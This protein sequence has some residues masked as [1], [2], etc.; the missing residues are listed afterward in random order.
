MVCINHRRDG[1]REFWQGRFPPLPYLESHP[2]PV[3]PAE[4][5][6]SPMWA[7]LDPHPSASSGQALRGGDS[8][9]D[10]RLFGWAAGPWALRAGF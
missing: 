5:E 10:F 4:R 6:S 9:A 3:I 2:L 8:T 1:A 7:D